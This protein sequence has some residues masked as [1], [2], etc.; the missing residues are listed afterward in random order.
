MK[1]VSIDSLP[2]NA[3]ISEPVFLDE[4]YIL[5]SP[6]VPISEAL[7][8]RL[9]EWNI[10]EV[11]TTGTVTNSLNLEGTETQLTTGTQEKIGR[12]SCRERV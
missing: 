11:L 6:E 3:Y 2:E 10:M 9:R 7:K 5:L 12:A 8:N 1:K 4:K